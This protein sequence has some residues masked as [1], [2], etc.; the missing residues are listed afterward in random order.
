MSKINNQFASTSKCDA[1]ARSPRK[2]KLTYITT[3]I[4]FDELLSLQVGIRTCFNSLHILETHQVHF[5]YCHQS[6]IEALNPRNE[7]EENEDTI[8]THKVIIKIIQLT[9]Y[10]PCNSH[11][12][13][14]IR[15]LFEYQFLLQPL[16]RPSI[17]TLNISSLIV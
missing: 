12:W 2:S 10:H 9:L 4:Y 11:N 8:I 15:L 17:K 13:Y 16:H 7:N 3:V 5:I 1:P 6:H 14:K